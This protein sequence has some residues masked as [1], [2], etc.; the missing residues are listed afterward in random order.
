M[1][2]RPALGR[3]LSALIPDAPAPAGVPLDVEIRRLAP[4]RRQPRVQMDESRLDELARSIRSNGVI[5][6]I[7]VRPVGDAYEIVAGERR[8]RAA[9]RAGLDRVPVVVRDV[10][11][12]Q[13]LQ[14]A[15]IENLQREDLNPIEEAQAYQRLTDDFHLKQEDIAAAVGKDRSS[16]ANALRLLKL[17]EEVQAEVA[18]GRLTMGHARALLALPDGR[19]QRTMAREVV[20]RG[21]SVR[22]TEARVRRTTDPPSTAARTPASVQDPN[23]KAAEDRL[24]LSLGARVRISRTGAGGRIEIDFASEAELQRLY[25]HLTR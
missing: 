11:D 14:V 13:L 6:P 22:E 23:T 18:N 4:N 10:A 7:V 5:Q 3:G 16:I 24:R 20:A 25:E 8:W 12:E 19:D 9:A 17:P 15:L 1:D 2:K 21:W